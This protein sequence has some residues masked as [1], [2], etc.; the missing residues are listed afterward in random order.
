ME[1]QNLLKQLDDTDKQILRV[2]QKHCNLKLEEIREEVEE[3]L[4]KRVPKTTIHSKIKRMENLGIIAGYRAILNHELLG[5]NVTAFVSLDY[6]RLPGMTTKSAEDYIEELKTFDGVQEIFTLAGIHD[7]LIKIKT[8]SVDTLAK[9]VLD[10]IRKWP[11]IT[12]SVTS[13]VYRPHLEET[14][15]GI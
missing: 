13:I 9:T 10:K 4:Q 14:R 1:N 8:D 15:I 3:A 6:E 5:K 2:L 11:G 7:I 12:R